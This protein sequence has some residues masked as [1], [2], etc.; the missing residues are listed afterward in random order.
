MN[1]KLWDVV[2][3]SG[4]KYGPW[5][6][7]SALLV[8]LLGATI[9]ITTRK[10]ATHVENALWT[11]ILFAAGV[12]VSFY[13]GRRSVR[14]AAQEVVRPQARGAARRIVSLGKGIRA[15]S[16]I[17]RL[18]R[19]SAEDLATTNNGVVPIEHI[20]LAYDTLDVHVEMQMNSVVDA[21]EDWREF[22]PAI[23]NELEVK[24]TD[25]GGA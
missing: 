19:E 11:F 1:S 25:G 8:G 21:I 4:R 17:L 18:S 12:G 2:V 15:F 16:E 23:I 9:A 20:Q 10:G 22:E 7:V 6:L 24:K 13:V 14:A 3:S 5:V